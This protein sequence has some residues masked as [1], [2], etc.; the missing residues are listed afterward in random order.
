MTLLMLL[1]VAGAGYVSGGLTA[2]LLYGAVFVALQSIFAKLGDDYSAF[3]GLTAWLVQFTVLLPALIGI[4]L[5]RNPSGFLS[6]SFAQ[7][8]PLIRKTKPV[9][10]VGIAAEV[11]IWFLAL[12]H[13]IHNWTFVILTVRAPA[14]LLP[15]HRGARQPG[16]VRSPDERGRGRRRHPARADRHR[17]A[18]HRRRPAPDRPRDRRGGLPDMTADALLAVE[19]VTVEFGGNRALTDVDIDVRVGRDHRAH[20]PERG[21]QDDALQRHHR[22]CW[23]PTAGRIR[24]D[25]RDV[26]RLDTHKR[27]RLGIARTFQ[28]LELFT[29][30]TV[31]DNLR[32]AG[33][34]RNTWSGLGRAGPCAGS[35]SPTKP[36]ACST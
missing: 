26:S 11:L 3:H 6:D 16:G 20:R 27:A 35:T 34:I 22:A 14:S 25:G 23:S 19:Q 4:G 17:P 8:G 36:S 1:V 33:E 2:G 30:L 31:R 29:D 5:G 28:R 18:V 13:T 12:R 7:F 21:G 24:F 10:F 9:L 15:T 32:V